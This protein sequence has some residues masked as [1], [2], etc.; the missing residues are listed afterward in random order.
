VSTSLDA[1]A[2]M[3]SFAGKMYLLGKEIGEL[4]LLGAAG[5]KG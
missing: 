2:H 3:H 4:A 1:D 5:T